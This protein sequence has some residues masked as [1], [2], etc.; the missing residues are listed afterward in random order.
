MSPTSES[1]NQE[2]RGAPRTALEAAATVRMANQEFKCRT[3]DLS[4]QGL[5]LMG[6]E[7]LVPAGTFMRVEFTLPNEAR[8]IDIDGILVQSSSHG[9]GMVWG[10]KLIEPR[11]DAQERIERYLEDHPAL[12]QGLSRPPEPEAVTIW[13]PGARDPSPESERIHPPSGHE[14]APEEVRRFEQRKLHE[15]SP[16]QSQPEPSWPRPASAADTQLVQM[17]EKAMSAA[18]RRRGAQARET[19]EPRPAAHRPSEGLLQPGSS[20]NL[21]V[22]LQWLYEQA[23]ATVQA[24]PSTDR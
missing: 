9:S 20:T 13:P 14:E 17:Y 8:A 18:S 5:A 1:L 11:V 24:R 19:P 22:E 4:T 7:S 2:R 16:S 23:T 12:E 21:D 3:R 15:S 6:H 10:L